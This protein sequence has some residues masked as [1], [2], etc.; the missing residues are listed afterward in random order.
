MPPSTVPCR[1][2]L[3]TQNGVSLFF[4]RQPPNFWPEHSHSALQ[5]SIFSEEAFCEA[6]CV[7]SSGKSMRQTISGAQVCLIGAQQPHSCDWRHEAGLINLYIEPDFIR[8]VVDDELK[9]VI[10]DEFRNVAVR[11]FLILD[12]ARDL[13]RHYL[14]CGFMSCSY[15]GSIAVALAERLLRAHLGGARYVNEPR[16]FLT[17]AALK[18]VNDYIEAH[19][20]EHIAVERLA[21]EARLSMHHFSRLLKNTLGLTPH[22]LI[23]QHRIL[24]ARDI[25]L[26]GEMNVAEVALAV[27]F[28][29]QSHLD[30]H[31]QLTFGCTP[32]SIRGGKR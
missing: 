6:T 1:P 2:Q 10:L 8:Q 23:V 22:K 26:K 15:F 29:D 25:L 28:C 31:F 5:I 9:D 17:K 16:G 19:V 11:D 27:G 18:R 14:R 32:S 3:Y 7:T 30:R 13:H 12:L 24:R 21:Q 4:D 20:S